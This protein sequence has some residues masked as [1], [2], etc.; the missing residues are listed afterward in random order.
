MSVPLRSF[1]GLATIT[2]I[3][4]FSAMRANLE[5]MGRGLLLIFE[6]DDVEKRSVG[7]WTIVD[8]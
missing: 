8:G 5:K 1:F 7:E 4:F 6:R 2:R 3:F